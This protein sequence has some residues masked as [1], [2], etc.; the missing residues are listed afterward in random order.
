MEVF[1]LSKNVL[2][3]TVVNL[4]KFANYSRLF[5]VEILIFWLQ[6]NHKNNSLFNYKAY[7]ASCD[8][9]VTLFLTSTADSSR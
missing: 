6:L 5:E 7:F 8:S 3:R 1:D 2:R 4:R 9:Y